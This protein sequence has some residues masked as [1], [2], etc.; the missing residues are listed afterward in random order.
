MQEV[1]KDIPNYEGLYQVSD[2]GRVKSLKRER[3]VKDKILNSYLDR[4]GYSR[5]FLC[6]EGKRKTV[7]IHQLVAM[8][9]L[10]HIP[11]GHEIVVDHIDNDKSN[12]RIENLQ[13]ITQRENVSKDRKIGTSKYTGV[14]WH[15]ASKKWVVSIRTSDKRKYLGYFDCEIEA[16]EAYKTALKELSK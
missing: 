12:N 2:H 15:K 7:Y 5:L 16:S 8:T 11:N 13:L 1:W 10:N 6:K 3:V 14:S 4:Y 9:F